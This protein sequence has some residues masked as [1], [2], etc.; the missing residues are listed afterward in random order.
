MPELSKLTQI[1]GVGTTGTSIDLNGDI[2]DLASNGGFE[3]ILAVGYQSVSQDD[4]LVKFQSGTASG[5][6]ADTT[7]Q[8][9]GKTTLYLDLYR[10]RHRFV[11]AVFEAGSATVAFRSLHTFAYGARVQPTTQ[12]VSTT[13]TYVQTPAVGS[14]TA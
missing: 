9:H 4:S 11:R 1:S 8:A 6:L 12:P 2:I 10:P 3:S 14:A 7:G 5:S 13:G